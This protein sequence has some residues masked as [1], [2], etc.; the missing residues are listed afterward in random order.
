MMTSKQFNLDLMSVFKRFKYD[1]IRL[2][3]LHGYDAD[4]NRFYLS[5]KSLYFDVN[6][7]RNDLILGHPQGQQI[8]EKLVHLSNTVK[9]WDSILIMLTKIYLF[10]DTVNLV[11]QQIFSIVG[12]M[13]KESQKDKS[14]VFTRLNNAWFRTGHQFRMCRPYVQMIFEKLGLAKFVNELLEF[15]QLANEINLFCLSNE[16]MKQLHD[17]TVFQYN[18]REFYAPGFYFFNQ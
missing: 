15:L 9:Q 13:P 6:T 8:F 17:N 11:F 7:I 10:F 3:I 14:K 5:G 4:Q 1:N 16:L 12:D 18:M 2:D